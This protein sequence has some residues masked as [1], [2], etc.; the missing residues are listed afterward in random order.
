MGSLLNLLTLTD[1]RKPD[2]RSEN[3]IRRIVPFEDCSKC[4]KICP[5]KAI[6]LIS[7]GISINESCDGCMVCLPICPTN[8]LNS[9]YFENRVAVQAKEKKCPVIICERIDGNGIRVPCPASLDLKQILCISLYLKPPITIVAKN[10]KDCPREGAMKHFRDNINFLA[11]NYAG[12]VSFTENEPEKSLIERGKFFRMVANNILSITINKDNKKEASK[13]FSK[14]KVIKI[15]NLY[16]ITKYKSFNLLSPSLSGGCSF[17]GLC[18]SSCPQNA[19]KIEYGNNKS[20]LKLNSDVCTSCKVC[21][22][23]CPEKSL[24]M[25]TDSNPSERILNISSVCICKICK[26]PAGGSEALCPACRSSKKNG[27]FPLT[28][29]PPRPVYQSKEM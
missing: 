28:I 26:R 23:I 18:V 1:Y 2:F 21:T 5:Q 9:L 13:D 16:G 14:K 12:L 10:C 3:C 11:T 19:L 17:C 20:S 7:G 27:Q 25:I 22:L 4:V 29:V 24:R 6:E 15:L 8:A